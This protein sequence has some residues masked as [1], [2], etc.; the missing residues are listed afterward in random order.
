MAVHQLRQ[1][2][3]KGGCCGC[4][5]LPQLSGVSEQ[6][7]GVGP[8]CPRRRGIDHLRCDLELQ[9]HVLAGLD[10]LGELPAPGFKGIDPGLDG[11]H[12]AAELRN[13]ELAPPAV[14]DERDHR[15]LGPGGSGVVAVA[16]D[17]RQR[18]MAVGEDVGLDGY[19]LAQRPLGR[20][21]AGVDLGRHRFDGD[22]LPAVG[23]RPREVGGWGRWGGPPPY[24]CASHGSIVP[25]SISL[26]YPRTCVRIGAWGC[27][28]RS[29]LPPA[30]SSPTSRSLTRRAS[31]QRWRAPGAPA[32]PGETSAWTCGPHCSARWRG[33]CGRTRPAMLRCSPPRWASP[34]SKP[35]ARSRN[36]PGRRPG[37]PTTPP[38]CWPT[39]RWRA[40]PPAA[41]SGS[42][43]WGWSWP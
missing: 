1:V 4:P 41:T 30:R 3:A 33:S 11:E 37:S 36:A 28:A 21:P 17:A 15:R 38:A 29:T 20:E 12:V 43:R 32:M 26:M 23:R 6:L 27:F 19:L 34:L 35:K 14:V 18:V 10:P 9:R 8:A 2:G 39:N 24:R 22:P 7:G 31:R 42:S 40:Q 13:R 16:D 25:R 5:S